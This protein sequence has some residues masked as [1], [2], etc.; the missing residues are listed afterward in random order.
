MAE[1]GRCGPG[2]A[3]R[4]GLHRAAAVRGLRLRRKAAPQGLGRL[5]EFGGVGAGGGERRS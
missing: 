1:G 4:G 5:W 3:L 2:P